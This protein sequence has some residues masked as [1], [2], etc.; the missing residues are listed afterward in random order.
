[1]GSVR[2]LLCGGQG[3][4]C[5]VVGRV[6]VA[7][8]GKMTLVAVRSICCGETTVLIIPFFVSSYAR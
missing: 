6:G 5:F 2:E 8:G 3:R 1:M 4:S 7:V